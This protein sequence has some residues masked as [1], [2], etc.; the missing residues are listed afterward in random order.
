MNNGKPM[1]TEIYGTN[2]S[3]PNVSNNAFNNLVGYRTPNSTQKI[4]PLRRKPVYL[5]PSES[6]RFA[7]LTQ[8][9]NSRNGMI[10]AIR[11][12]PN[13]NVRPNEKRKMIQYILALYTN[14]F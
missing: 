6:L 12:A 13:M 3:D 5:N 14:D 4:T 11:N 1:P 9:I 8:N 2:L 10:R 7:K